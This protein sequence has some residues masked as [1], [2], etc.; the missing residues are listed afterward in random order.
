MNLKAIALL[1]LAIA[2]SVLLIMSGE[3]LR[4]GSDQLSPAQ[5]EMS[6]EQSQLLTIGD[7]YYL[8]DVVDNGPEKLQKLLQRAEVLSKQ[9]SE[10][11]H[12]LTIAMVIH[13]PDM[14][15]FDKKNYLKQKKLVDTAARLEADGV[16]DFKVCQTIARSRGIKESSFPA[17]MEMVPFA[18][19]EIDRL[20]AEGY[21]HF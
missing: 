9:A 3:R 19:A 15:I 2:V 12:K 13:G 18:P 10:T 1:I 17:F 11:E 6:A 8:F 5:N 4:S 14:D 20:E 7:T 16:I 21:V